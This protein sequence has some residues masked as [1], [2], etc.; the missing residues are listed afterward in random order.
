MSIDDLLSLLDHME[1]ADATTWAAIDTL[2]EDRVAVSDLRER[3]FHIHL[4][5]QLYLAMWRRQRLSAIPQL[6]EYSDLASVRAWGRVFYSE[7]RVLLAHATSEQLAEPVVVPFSE[8][9]APP[10]GSI[11]HATFAQT[12]L[13]VALHTAHH[14]GQLATRIRELGGSP[15]TT[16]LVIWTWTGRPRPQWTSDA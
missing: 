6:A 11:T 1:W 15:P 3:L 14:R 12:V 8:R 4:V 10:G 16:D 5:Q 2:P 13:Q 9:L 7:A